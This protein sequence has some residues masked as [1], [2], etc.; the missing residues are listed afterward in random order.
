MMKYKAVTLYIEWFFECLFR[1]RFIEIDASYQVLKI[2]PT[3]LNLMDID[4]SMF[5]FT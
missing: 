1:Y 4:I 2:D 3:G 5:Q